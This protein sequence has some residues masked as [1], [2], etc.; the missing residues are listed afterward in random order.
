M[1]KERSPFTCLAVATSCRRGRA[2]DPRK[3]ALREAAYIRRTRFTK[4]G[5]VLHDFSSRAEDLLMLVPI[6]PVGAPEWVHRPFLRWQ[7]ADE[8]VEQGAVDAVRAW[9]VCGDLKPGLSSGA[10]MDDV[11]SLVRAALPTEAVAE[12]AAHVPTNKPAHAHILVAP[13]RV[14]PTS[15]GP[16]DYGLYDRLYHVLRAAWMAWLTT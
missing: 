10:W 14:G 12:I 5:A 16:V 2:G 4:G 3:T 1:G 6:V 11:T 7:L 9:H 8:A 13:R 15:Y